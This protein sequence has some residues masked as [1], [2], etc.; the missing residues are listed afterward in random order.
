M[1]FVDPKTDFA[2][3]R[4]F[5]SEDSKTALISFINASLRLEG[6]RLVESVEIKN[7]YLSADL[8]IMKE[9]IVDIACTDKSGI[10]YLV[11][12]QVNNVKGF[13]N[14]MIFTEGAGCSRATA[15]RWGVTPQ[16]VAARKTRGYS[17]QAVK[18][19]TTPSSTTWF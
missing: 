13:A 12:M 7:P 5:G 19:T 8:P 15:P 6:D 11:E 1:R 3:K 9:S 2:F 17:E 4:I 16:E 14:R 18:G 10:R